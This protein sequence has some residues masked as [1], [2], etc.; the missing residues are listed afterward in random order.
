MCYMTKQNEGA[1]F[2]H[3]YQPTEMGENR[4]KEEDSQHSLLFQVH[5]SQKKNRMN[6]ITI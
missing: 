4:G 2:Q 3:H 1:L 5:T 6:K